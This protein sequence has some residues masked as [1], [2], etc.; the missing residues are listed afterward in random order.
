MFVI[1]R[2]IRLIRST[3]L[4]WFIPALLLMILTAWLFPGPGLS[5]GMFSLKMLAGAGIS[6]IFFLYGLRLSL[7]Q[8]M[9]CLSNWKLHLII[10]SVTFIVFPLLAL[11]FRGFIPEGQFY[12]LWLGVFFLAS[13]PSTVSSAVV[14]VSL[15]GGNIPAAVFNASLSSIAGIFIT[16]LWVGLVVSGGAAG[17]DMSPVMI[18]LSYQ[19]CC[20][21]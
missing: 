4:D 6:I 13:L 21:W 16:P 5:S 9:G 8:L 14:M 1:K 17:F 10:Q 18:K 12:F 2:I 15:A 20:H 19:V 11:I 3:G 7:S